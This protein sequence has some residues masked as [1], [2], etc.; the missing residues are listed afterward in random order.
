[1]LSSSCCVHEGVVT[2]LM[3]SMLACTVGAGATA[4]LAEHQGWISYQSSISHM[5]SPSDS[6]LSSWLQCKL[7]I[8]APNLF[9]SIHM[10]CMLHAGPGAEPWPRNSASLYMRASAQIT[11]LPVDNLILLPIA[12]C[13]EI[14]GCCSR[15]VKHLVTP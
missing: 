14:V 15:W 6:V 5:P 1:M 11:V 7:Q 2:T 12:T 8:K 9:L 4:A 13:T 10:L 3:W